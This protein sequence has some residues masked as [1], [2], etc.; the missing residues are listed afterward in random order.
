MEKETDKANPDHSLIFKNITAQVIM[1]LTEATEGHNTGIDMA[2]IGAPHN[3]C[4]APIEATA[5]NLTM[6]HHIDHVAD[7]SYIEVLQLIDPETTIDHT[8]NHLTD[9]QG[10]P[11]TDQVHIPAD[12]EENLTSRRT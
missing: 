7:H 9:L 8:H 1:I 10:R 3:D 5:I 6:K 12:H 2:T 11:H 4:T